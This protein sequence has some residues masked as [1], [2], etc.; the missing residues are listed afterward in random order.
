MRLSGENVARFTRWLLAVAVVYVSSYALLRISRY[1]VH[2]ELTT[3]YPPSSVRRE[4]VDDPFP[5]QEGN[6]FYEFFSTRNQIGC[7]HIQKPSS[8]LGEFILVPLYMPLAE[9]EMLLRGYGYAEWYIVKRVAVFERYDDAGEEVYYWDSDGS[10]D[11][12]FHRWQR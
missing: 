10:T 4:F 8:R 7:G 11:R 3:F 12:R 9:V 1:F 5:T 6:V 2:Q